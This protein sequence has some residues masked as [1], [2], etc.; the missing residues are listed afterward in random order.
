MRQRPYFRALIATM[1][2]TLSNLEGVKLIRHDDPELSELKHVL[3]G[4][5]AEFESE[6]GTMEL[7][8]TGAD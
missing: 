4:K 3:K 1:K 2:Q 8:S 6:D 5:I 7:E